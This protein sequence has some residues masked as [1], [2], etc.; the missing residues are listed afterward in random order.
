MAAVFAVGSAMMYAVQKILVSSSQ[1]NE[2]RINRQSS[3][4]NG[5]PPEPIVHP[6][7]LSAYLYEY[8]LRRLAEKRKRRRK[9]T[10]T[11]TATTAAAAR[12]ATTAVPSSS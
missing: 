5:D 10:A 11:T 4:A 1:H 12:T 2:A 8:K 6:K 3:A 9:T 7:D